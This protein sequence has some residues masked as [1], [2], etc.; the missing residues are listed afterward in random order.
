[1]TRKKTKKMDFSGDDRS[2]NNPFASLGEKFGIIAD[3]P[4]PQKKPDPEPAAQNEK[5]MLLVRKEKRA[6]GKVVTCIYHLGKE[7]EK[8]LK[9]LK[10]RLATGGTEAEDHIELR[11]EHVGKAADY[12]EE[13]GFKVRRG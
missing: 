10:V 4:L 9:Q 13:Q 1:M 11:G 12:L 8:V 3:Q 6:K 5:S 7:S 2:I